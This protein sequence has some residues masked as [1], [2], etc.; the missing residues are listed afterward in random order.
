[1]QYVHLGRTP[2]NLVSQTTLRELLR[3]V[4]LTLPEG[5][6]L[7]FVLRPNNVY[8]YY[9]VVEAIMLADV[10]IFKLVLSVPLKTVNSHY[11]LYKMVVLP[12]RISDNAYAQFVIG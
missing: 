9:E 10:H 1:M 2:L 3:N 11:E 12:T 4:T 7:I 8:L 5:F 6:E